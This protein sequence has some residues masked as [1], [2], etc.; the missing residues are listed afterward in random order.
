MTGGILGIALAPLLVAVKYLTGWAIVPEPFW[1]PMVKPILGALLTFGTPVRMWVVYGRLY[2]VALVLM[3][4]GVVTLALQLGRRAP[5]GLWILTAGLALVIGGDA[6]HTA[7]WHQHGLTIPTPGSNPVANTGYAVHMMGMNVVLV[8]SLMAGITM[9]RRRLLVP[10]LAWCFILVAPCAVAL[11]LT[12]LPT[13]PS[14]GL[15]M[16]SL[17][18]IAVGHRLGVGRLMEPAAVAPGDGR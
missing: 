13:S 9:L 16:F 4:G 10:W 14:G 2:T 8:G 15:W 12:L 7:T 5:R 1:I 18:M 11:S 6:V 3:L 17:A